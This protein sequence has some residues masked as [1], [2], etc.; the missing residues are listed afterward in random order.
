L[1]ETALEVTRPHAPYMLNVALET[2]QPI[3]SLY[4]LAPDSGGAKRLVR[5]STG[6]LRASAA[7][8]PLARGQVGVEEIGG[9]EAG[10][11]P[12]SPGKRKALIAA[13]MVMVLWCLG[14]VVFDGLARRRRERAPLA[15]GR[16]AET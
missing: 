14:M 11:K 1:T 3:I 12:V 9:V 7:R 5:A 16:R 4:A 13:F 2:S 6:A 8:F 10:T 15:V